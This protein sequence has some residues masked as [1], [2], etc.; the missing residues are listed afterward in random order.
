MGHLGSVS[1]QIFH[2]GSVCSIV[3][4]DVS[5]SVTDYH[6]FPQK[7]E[8]KSRNLERSDIHVYFLDVSVEST[9][10]LYLVSGW[11]EETERVFNVATCHHCVLI[12]CKR[13]IIFIV[14]VK[15]YVFSSENQS[16]HLF[17]RFVDSDEVC[18]VSLIAVAA[19]C[20]N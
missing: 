3:Q 15:P 4:S 16:E 14:I 8:V 11:S 1:C 6:A 7:I 17:G 20:F 5:L 18:N 12:C 2:F 9:P 10:Y 19:L 13:V